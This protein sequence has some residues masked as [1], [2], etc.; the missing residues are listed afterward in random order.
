VSGKKEL[1]QLLEE[2]LTEIC[3]ITSTEETSEETRIAAR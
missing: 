2:V 3:Q 1:R